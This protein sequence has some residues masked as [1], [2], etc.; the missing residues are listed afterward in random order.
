MK[1]RECRRK[2]RKEETKGKE[3]KVEEM[4]NRKI[5]ELGLREKEESE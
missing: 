1:G 5:V 3:R 4:G 2:E